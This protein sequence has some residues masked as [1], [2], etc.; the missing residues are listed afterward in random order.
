MLK[1]FFPV[2]FV[3]VVL[4]MILTKP[5][6]TLENKANA[7]ENPP[8]D[9]NHHSMVQHLESAHAVVMGAE[10]DV[11]IRMRV[12]GDYI[13]VTFEPE[14]LMRLRPD[15]LSAL[16]IA[17]PDTFMSEERFNTF[18]FMFHAY[19]TMAPIAPREGLEIAEHGHH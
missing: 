6:V 12:E 14:F 15:A 10:G 7:Q 18:L 19:L 2:I 9:P 8:K 1:K 3:A 13:H 4:A 11:D 5:K 16:E 17:K